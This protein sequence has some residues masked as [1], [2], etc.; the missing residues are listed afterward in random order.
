MLYLSSDILFTITF[1]YFECI[2]ND[3]LWVFL[4]RQYAT[5]CYQVCAK[6]NKVVIYLM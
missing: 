6:L 5:V 2:Q 4:I 3:S 1:I